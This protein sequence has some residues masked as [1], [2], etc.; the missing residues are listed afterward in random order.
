MMPQLNPLL[1]L[2]VSLSAPAAASQ[3]P[4]GTADA[5]S[6]ISACSL[7]PTELMVKVG[8]INKQMVKYLEPSE[9]PMGANVSACDYASVRLQVNPFGKG[10]K[11]RQP[12]KEWQAV[13]GVGDGA[14]F[15][16]NGTHYAELIVWT[17]AHHFTIQFGVP[18]GG[19][20]ESIRPNTIELA[21]AIVAKLR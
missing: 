20:P 15:R 2:L 7:L 19:T 9:E 16:P 1:L 13:S 21:N 10:S 12:A 14:F 17:G 4:G 8:G 5:A 18:T 3:A 6:R 11:P